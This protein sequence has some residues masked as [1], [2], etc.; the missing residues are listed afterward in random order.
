MTEQ[1]MRDTKAPTHDTERQLMEYITGLASQDHDYGT[2]VYAM[3]LAATATFNFMARRLGVTGS[4][5]SCADLDILK[6]TRRYKQGF[7]ILDYS[8]L[9][10]PQYLTNEHFPGF[11]ELLAEKRIELATL[12]RKMLAEQTGPISSAVK[13]HWEHLVRQ[14]TSEELKDDA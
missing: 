4:Q 6:R 3:S 14:A 8:N 12:A 13:E 2:C 11:R 7:R 1:E 9:M 10:Y 5:A